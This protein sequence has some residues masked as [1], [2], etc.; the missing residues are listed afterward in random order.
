M[1]YTADLRHRD[2]SLTAGKSR[3][4]LSSM[5]LQLCTSEYLLVVYAIRF[6][7]ATPIPAPGSCLQFCGRNR[8]VKN[9][10]L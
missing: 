10:A 5:P 6:R 4:T 3:V 2:Q 7:D 9:A 8:L 1:T